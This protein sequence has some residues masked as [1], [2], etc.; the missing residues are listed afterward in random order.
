MKGGRNLAPAEN[1]G[2]L[3]QFFRSAKWEGVKRAG[4]RQVLSAVASAAS[5]SRLLGLGFSP[6]LQEFGTIL[7]SWYWEVFYLMRLD[8]KVKSAKG[9]HVAMLR[10][11]IDQPLPGTL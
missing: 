5:S 8:E 3:G 6:G 10:I 11:A 4:L 2:G 1:K 9:W 7:G